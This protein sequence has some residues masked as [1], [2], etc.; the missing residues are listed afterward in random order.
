MCLDIVDERLAVAKELGALATINAAGAD[1]N[2]RIRAAAGQRG[3]DVSI[4]CSGAESALTSAIRCTRSGGVVLMV[5]LGKPDMTLP[6]TEAAIREVDLRGIFRCAFVCVFC[7]F[8]LYY[9]Y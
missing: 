5:G 9:Y 8:I 7:L 2:E 4:D 6:I 1:T 3:I